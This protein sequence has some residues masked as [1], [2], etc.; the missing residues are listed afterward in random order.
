VCADDGSG[1]G[2][3]SVRDR[4][5]QLYVFTRCVITLLASLTVEHEVTGRQVNKELGRR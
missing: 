2:E 3:G 5:D 1:G 4:R